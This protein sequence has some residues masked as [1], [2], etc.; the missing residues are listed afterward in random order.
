MILAY[1]SDFAAGL[2]SKTMI[3]GVKYKFL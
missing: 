1:S 2:E 3:L